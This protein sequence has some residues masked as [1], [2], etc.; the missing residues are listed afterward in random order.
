[1]FK[2]NYVNDVLKL[3]L[4]EY[5]FVHNK[6]VDGGCSLKRPD[7]RYECFSHSVLL[8]LDEQ[9]HKSA[10][11]SCEN[12]RTMTLFRDL[13][14]RPMVLIRFNPDAYLKFTTDGEKVIHPGCFTINQETGRLDVGL[15]EFNSRLDQLC[16]VLKQAIAFVPDK[17]LTITYLYYD[18]EV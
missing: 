4:P 1:M 9:Q 14:D 16:V 3:R 18:K 13:G 12:K 2:E 17:E 10:S 8:E 11:Y 7:W 6:I 15:V 5:Q